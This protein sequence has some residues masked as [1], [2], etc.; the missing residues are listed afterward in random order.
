M[1][2]RSHI[3]VLA[4]ETQVHLRRH[5]IAVNVI[6]HHAYPVGIAAP[7]PYYRT[8]TVACQSRGIQVIRVKIGD[9]G[10][11]DLGDRLVI[12]PEN[13]PQCITLCIGFRDE[14][15]LNIVVI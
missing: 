10:S 11:G 1:Q 4:G 6:F 9:T 7:A 15:A 2:P 12:R 5:R 14:V 13:L 8:C 3:K